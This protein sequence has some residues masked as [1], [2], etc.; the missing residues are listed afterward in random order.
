MTLTLPN[1]MIKMKQGVGRLIRS[2]SDRGVVLILDGRIT[3]KF[4]SR[5]LFSS[6]PEGYYPEDTLNENIESKIES[7]LF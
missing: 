7:F 3:K 5:L 4:Y 1:A 6:I 2:E